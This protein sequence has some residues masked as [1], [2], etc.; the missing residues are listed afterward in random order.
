[1]PIQSIKSGT[2]SRSTA[3]GNAIILP[4]DFESI[5]TT[6]VDGSGQASVT[7]SSIPQTF[8]HLQIRCIARYTGTAYNNLLGQ[9]NGDTTFTNYRWHYL[10]G[11]GSSAAAGSVQSSGAPLSMGLVAGTAQTTGVFAAQFIDILDYTN[12][13][14]YTTIRVLNGMDNNGSG[15]IRLVSGL[16]MNTNAITSITLTAQGGNNFAQYSSFAL[17]GI[18][19]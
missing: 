18:R 12:T 19:G 4:G 13:N 6:V 10:T 2:L 8:T 3:V 1:M 14:K 9:F 17:Y 16:W 15:E 5:A 7:F 11:D